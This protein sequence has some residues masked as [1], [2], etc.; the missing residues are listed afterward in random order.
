MKFNRLIAVAALAAVSLVT[1]LTVASQVAVAHPQSHAEIIVDCVH[2]RIQFTARSY[3]G[4]SLAQTVQIPAPVSS[5]V[6]MEHHVVGLAPYTWT[7]DF[8]FTTDLTSVP[9]GSVDVN[10]DWADNKGP[11]GRANTG[12]DQPDSRTLT[13][14]ATACPVETTTT[15]TTSTTTTTTTPEVGLIP[16]ITIEAP[17]E[18]PKVSTGAP[19]VKVKSITDYTG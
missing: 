19:V 16:P 5:A 10:L 1:G 12:D 6:P 4:E 15:T 8:V 7:P 13:W 14:G 17:P 2:G 9:A 11:D 3:N 18:T